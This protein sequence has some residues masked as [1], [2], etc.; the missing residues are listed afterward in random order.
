MSRPE[1][2]YAWRKK[3]GADAHNKIHK[4]KTTKNMTDNQQANLKEPS[5]SLHYTIPHSARTRACFGERRR[6]SFFVPKAIGRV[7]VRDR[8]RWSIRY[9]ELCVAPLY[10]I[11]PRA[12][13]TLR[14]G[15]IKARQ[16]RMCVRSKSWSVPAHASI[17][18]QDS[19]I[20]G[21]PRPGGPGREREGNARCRKF[22]DMRLLVLSNESV[23]S[24]WRAVGIP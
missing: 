20:S 5:H 1:K 10:Y 6:L 3:Q 22:V 13:A 12:T 16:Q 15:C 23:G 11:A 7:I 18:L 2:A 9:P 17:G 19:W 8:V 14:P 4:K 21:R 24:N